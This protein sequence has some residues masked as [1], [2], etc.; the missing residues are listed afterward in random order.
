MH[1]CFMQSQLNIGIF[2]L[3]SCRKCWQLMVQQRWVPMSPTACFLNNHGNGS[4]I[5]MV[6]PAIM[7]PI[8]VYSCI[9]TYIHTHSPIW[10]CSYCEGVENAFTY[11]W[12]TDS[13]PLTVKAIANKA[14]FEVL[15]L[16]GS[17]A[18]ALQIWRKKAKVMIE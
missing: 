18:N 8:Y 12:I 10:L 6:S 2:L 5:K 16:A 9:Y 11:F 4:H 1:V 3:F 17:I 15:S 13:C 7:T 14:P